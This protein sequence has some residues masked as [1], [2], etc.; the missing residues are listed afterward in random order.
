MVEE[1]ELPIPKKK[2]LA[3]LSWVDLNAALLGMAD[4]KELRSWTMT[5]LRA[6]RFNCARRCYGRLSAARK[7]R[8]LR[9]L[10]EQINKRRKKE[11]A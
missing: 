3:E 8:E 9:E 1:G 4:E 6:G 10:G 2:T 5:F 7:E 11:A